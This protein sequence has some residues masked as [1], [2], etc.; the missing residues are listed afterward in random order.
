MD[1]LLVI[2]VESDYGWKADTGKYEETQLRVAK[3]IKATLDKLRGE[4][5][6]IIFV[7]FPFFGDYDLAERAQLVRASFP[8]EDWEAWFQKLPNGYKSLKLNFKRPNSCLACEN[9]SP[10]AP[11]LEHRHD[12]FEPV[13]FKN[14]TDAFTNRSLIRYLNKRNTKSIGLA[15]CSTTCCVRDT[16]CGAVKEGLSVELLQDC[17]YSPFDSSCCQKSEWLNTVRSNVPK[18]Y[19]GTV[20]VQIV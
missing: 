8:F 4:R 6:E 7:T 16:A 11:F 2:D 20:S 13:F 5:T 15:G 12:P 3:N 18:I 19:E 1:A 10:L 17:I 9:P 14:K